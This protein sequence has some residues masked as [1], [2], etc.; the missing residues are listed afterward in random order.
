MLLM[1]LVVVPYNTLLHKS[2]RLASKIK[3]KDNIIIIDEA[4]N[5][6]DAIGNMHSSSV[7][8][9]QVGNLIICLK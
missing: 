1:Q 6:L 8:G 2:T 5:L 4:H 3:L 7:T 9:N